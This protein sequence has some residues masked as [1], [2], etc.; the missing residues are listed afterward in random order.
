MSLLEV[1]L[2]NWLLL[3][4]RRPQ[5][6]PKPAET[7]R[8][9]FGVYSRP[10]PIRFDSIRYPATVQADGDLAC[11]TALRGFQF[12]WRVLEHYLLHYGLKNVLR[13]TQ[14]YNAKKSDGSPNKS[15][16]KPRARNKKSRNVSIEEMREKTASAKLSDGLKERKR[17]CH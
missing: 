14:K 13:K 17:G 11:T 4:E 9:L 15:S 10:L 5:I 16:E 3:L 7:S 2:E 12:D 1:P 8:T 6:A